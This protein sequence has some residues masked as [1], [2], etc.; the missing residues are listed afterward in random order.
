M[1]TKQMIKDPN[2]LERRGV[3]VDIKGDLIIKFKD[4]FAMLKYNE[5]LGLIQVNRT[6]LTSDEMKNLRKEGIPL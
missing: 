6:E 3:Y 1:D 5:E 4:G 2:E